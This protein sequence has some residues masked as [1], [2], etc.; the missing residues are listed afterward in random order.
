MFPR[1]RLEF[2]G[3]MRVLDVVVFHLGTVCTSSGDV[4]PSLVRS[5]D[6]FER[7]VDGFS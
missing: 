6:M 1:Q 4:T 7:D 3:M 5:C 2:V